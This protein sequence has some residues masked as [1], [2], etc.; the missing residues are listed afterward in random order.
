MPSSDTLF[1]S[2]ATTSAASGPCLV[3]V[4][5][6]SRDKTADLRRSNGRRPSGATP[7]E[8]IGEVPPEWV[9]AVGDALLADWERIG[10]DPHYAELTVLT[11]CRIWRYAL[12]RRHGSKTAAAEWALSID[13]ALDE[14]REALRQRR[15]D[16]TGSINGEQVRD[17]LA[18]VR[19][20][21]AAE[22]R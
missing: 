20:R 12:E 7:A 16:Q 13:P 6:T 10:D 5:S 8:L 11:A 19:A 1:A 9:L 22:M 17:L 14:V 2:R 18:V 3:H 15:G 4:W 21:I